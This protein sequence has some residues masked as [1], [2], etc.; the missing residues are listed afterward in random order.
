MNANHK[1]AYMPLFNDKM[2]YCIRCCTPETE[3]NTS[4]D[5]LGICQACRSS[6]QKMHINWIEREKQ[7][8]NILDKA[9]NKSGDN[10]D[11]II[12][13]SGGKD[14]VFQLHV[15]CRV[16][17]MKPLAV[18]FNHN[19]YSETGW[20]NLIN[21]LEEFNIDHIMFTPNR[22]LVNDLSRRSLELIGD[23][24]W[25]CHS[26]VGAFPLHIASKFGIPLIIYGEPPS[27]GHNTASYFEPMKY[28]RYFYTTISAIK[29]PDDMICEKITSKDIYPFQ[30]PSQEECDAA[31]VEILHLGDYYFWDDERQTEFVRLHYGW[32]QTD[33]EQT[34]KRYKSA[35]CIM[36]GAHD[37]TC[38]LK[39]GY[40]RTTYHANHDVR[41][42][43][44]MRH[45]G[46]ELIDR[47]EPVRPEV[48]DYFLE[49]ADLDEEEFLEIMA[50]LR[51]TPLKGASLKVREKDR[52][53]EETLLPFSQQIVKRMSSRRLK[54][55]YKCIDGPYTC[56][57]STSSDMSSGSEV[58]FENSIGRILELYGERELSPVDL[59]KAVIERYERMEP[60]VSAWETFNADHLI[61]QAKESEARL[62]SGQPCGLL[63]GIPVGVKDIFNT[64]D[65]P[66]QMGSPIW[67]GFTPGNDARAVFALR[68]AG[69]VIPG[70][71]VTAEFAVHTLGKTRNPHD[72][73]KTPGT[74]SSGSAAA[75]ASGMVPF[76]LG[77][78]TAASI[79]R[80]ASFCGVYGMKP[81]F[82]LIP[83]T[84]ILKTTDTLDTVGFFALWFEDLRRIFDV[85]R[86]KGRN[87]P[88][89]YSILSDSQRQNRPASR[90]WKIGVVKTHVWT[91]AN[92]Y[93]K[94]AL[95]DFANGLDSTHV[96][97]Q[98]IELPSFMSNAHAVH[99]LIYDKTLS[100]YFKEE[101]ENERLVS[102]LMKEIIRHGL[103][104]TPDDY[105]KALRDQE[106]MV[107]EMDDYMADWDAIICLS[108]AG[109]AP[110]R[111]Q[112]EQQD[113]GLMW[114]L[115]GLP[116]ISAP[117]F[118][119]P[120]GLPFG[121]QLIAR[122]Y[123]DYLLLNFAEY[124]VQ[125]GLIPKTANPALSKGKL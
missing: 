24:C 72:T 57:D 51:K 71:T 93:A 121:L 45:E 25:H 107:L 9:R 66:T 82:G 38:Y 11:C 3:E 112:I 73:S 116:A 110:E 17:G 22:S 123:N 48:L 60:I 64:K 87:Y 21:C 63:E 118:V 68:E 29:T 101:Y 41:N 49:I 69:A 26:G 122:R 56:R 28:D 15:L 35:E 59:A 83:R 18:T 102:P 109:Q 27:E 36:P 67:R 124:L 94:S 111:S 1:T 12:P 77:T 7:L 8:R 53:C 44:L 115:T 62:L 58:F 6:E 4:F 23:P 37:F 80:P 95:L 13:I 106:K 34:Y 74:S 2:R 75:I 65:F 40:G 85:L 31:G 97:V 108:T 88:F 96:F 16:Y 98:E 32:L 103:Q 33:I 76:A 117:A 81:S 99:S 79:T 90:P 120:E 78:Q 70:K 30:L 20:Y 104:I 125:E 10:Y 39:R 42:G 92:D 84:A 114:T 61:K 14:S 100:Y 52:P 119:S 19:W 55:P 105:R 5:E 47:I 54:N 113:S 46:F 43:M 86:V 50:M 89:V 91:Q